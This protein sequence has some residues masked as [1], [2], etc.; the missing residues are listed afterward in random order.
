[1]GRVALIDG[2]I[3]TR[4]YTIAVEYEL[5][6]LVADYVP[7]V[8]TIRGKKKTTAFLKDN[9]EYRILDSHSVVEPIETVKV[10]IAMALDQIKRETSCEEM[11]I[12]LGEQGVPTFRHKLYE[13]Y[14]AHRSSK[15]PV[16]YQAIYDWLV[17][18]HNAETFH[19]LEADDAIGIVNSQYDHAVICSNDKD[20]LTL[21]GMHYNFITDEKRIVSEAEADVHLFIQILM[22]DS[23]DGIPGLKGVG[24]AKATTMVAG[25][26]NFRA[27][28]DAVTKA[29]RVRSGDNWE[30]EFMLNARLVYILRKE[31]DSFEQLLE[32][33]N[34]V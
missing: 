4:R 21:P 5:F 3:L 32:R 10:N 11:R 34:V 17:E 25:C 13:P 30:E 14:K 1:M 28:Y 20:M 6:D 33:H 29:Y 19:E 18:E 2:D 26:N 12:F 24:V 9:P 16:H 15:R 22:G 31:G 27:L 8:E 7:E 23:A